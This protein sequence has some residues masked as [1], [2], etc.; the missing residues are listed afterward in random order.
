ME[1]CRE[2]PGAQ[3]TTVVRLDDI[4]EGAHDWRFSRGKEFPGAKGS[5]TVINDQPAPGQSSLE[6]AGDFT[7]GGA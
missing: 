4:L 6:L 1:S 2:V 5:L 3:V 7:P